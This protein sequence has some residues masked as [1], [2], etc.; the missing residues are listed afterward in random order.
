MGSFEAAASLIL[1]RK[2]H[3][4]APHPS[5]GCKGRLVITV[6]GSKQLLGEFICQ[7]RQLLSGILAV[8]DEGNMWPT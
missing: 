5:S 2:L 1:H 4:H 7:A 8:L 6:S 3:P